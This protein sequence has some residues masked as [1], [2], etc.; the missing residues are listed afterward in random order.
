MRCVVSETTVFR[1]ILPPL[2]TRLDLSPPRRARL[3]SGT[4]SHAGTSERPISRRSS[5]THPL[6][7]SLTR[8][9][10]RNLPGR[11]ELIRPDFIRLRGEQQV[12]ALI[13]R[14][15]P[16]GH[17]LEDIATDGRFVVGVVVL[18]DELLDL[19]GRE[20]P[21]DVEEDLNVAHCGLTVDQLENLT[22]GLGDAW[23]RCARVDIDIDIDI[24]VEVYVSVSTSKSD[25]LS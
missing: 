17:G 6:P 14:L 3:T 24:D 16:R 1:V 25:S 22:T 10:T 13:V 5:Y 9:E 8:L 11:R 7:R 20:D 19:R 18:A 4:F 23:T 12:I 15:D 21:A 2:L